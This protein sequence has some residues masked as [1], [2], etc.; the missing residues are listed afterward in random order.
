MKLYG[1]PH[2][3]TVKKARVWLDEN[4]IP[5]TFH[6]VKKQ[7]V[8]QATLDCWLNQYAWEKLVN[9]AGLTWRKLSDEE[10]AK[11]TDKTSAAALMIA[12]TSV[13]KRPILEQ[14]QVILMLG[15]NDAL[16]KEILK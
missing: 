5:Y 1:I 13:I 11:V 14:D 6:D 9:R 7:G 15:F 2:C 4:K 16:Y 10:K 12:K 3:S 8:S